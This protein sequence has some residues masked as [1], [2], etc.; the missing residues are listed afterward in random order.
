MPLTVMSGAARAVVLDLEALG[1]DP[2][3]YLERAGL[4]RED[5]FDP[6]R[7]L[8]AGQTESLWAAAAEYLRD[9]VRAAARLPVGAYQVVD[10]IVAKSETVGAALR[11]I[12]A[13][14]PLVDPR[15]RM[16][17]TEAAPGAQ[18]ACALSMLTVDG[19]PVPPLAQQFTFAA[20]VL[21]SRRF[22]GVDWPLE[23]V[24]FTFSPSEAA[25]DLEHAFGCRVSFGQQTARL[26]LSSSTFSLP[27][28]TAEREILP[29]LEQ[30][31]RKQL[32][33]MGIRD[34]PVPGLRAA[35]ISA[36]AEGRPT[37]TVLARRLGASPRS[38]QR[39]LEE[40]ATSFSS[41]L[42]VVRQGLARAH[43]GAGDLSIAEIAFVLG[44]SDQPAFTRAFSRWTGVTPQVFRAQ[45]RSG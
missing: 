32:Q 43:L 30:H 40:R 3:P 14:F 44:F 28:P 20:V 45:S 13:Y 19:S 29:L 36:C 23:R 17:V 37:L 26:L 35:L 1:V 22:C 15:V 34:E 18:S 21:R 16:I 41:E 10:F 24:E 2:A 9:P 7:R 25:A 38:L 12:A 6:D 4:L 31:A 42:D 27:L 39:R 8:S 11:R 33:E 5:V